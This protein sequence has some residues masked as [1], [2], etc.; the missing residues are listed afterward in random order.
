MHNILSAT[1]KS[2]IG[3]KLTPNRCSRLIYKK[4]FQ[5]LIIETNNLGK[6]I[7]KSIIKLKGK[8]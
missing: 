7:N 5:K 4:K 8:N 3:R 1:T 2:V 6:L